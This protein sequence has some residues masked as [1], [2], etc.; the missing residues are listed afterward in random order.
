MM[1]CLTKMVIN[2]KRRSVLSQKIPSWFL[3][4]LADLRRLDGET[5]FLD[6]DGKTSAT[7][8]VLSPDT[9]EF[10]VKTELPWGRGT[11]VD[12]FCVKDDQL[13][14]GDLDTFMS[15]AQDYLSSSSRAIKP[16]LQ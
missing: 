10:F 15:A 11:R 16:R 6:E 8:V 14:Q 3:G 1:F 13:C 5:R 4:S 12:T 7:S 9:F 2:P